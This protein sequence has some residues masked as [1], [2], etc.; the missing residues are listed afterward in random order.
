MIN[1]ALWNNSSRK[2][3]NKLRKEIGN[4]REPRHETEEPVVPQNTEE[5]REPYHVIGVPRYYTEEPYHVIE[6][7]RV[8]RYYTEEP[9]EPYHVIGVPRYYTEEPYHVIEEPRVPR[10]QYV[11]E[12]SYNYLIPPMRQPP[13]IQQPLPMRQQAQ[14]SQEQMQPP[15][16]T[17]TVQEQMQPSQAQISQEQMQPPPQTKDQTQ[18]QIQKANEK[19]QKENKPKKFLDL[20][21]S[22]MNEEEEE[23]ETISEDDRKTIARFIGRQF[24]KEIVK[25]SASY[26]DKIK[27][28]QEKI[29]E[30]TLKLAAKEASK[31]R[32]I[33]DSLWSC[34]SFN[35]KIEEKVTEKVHEKYKK[36]EQSMIVLDQKTIELERSLFEVRKYSCSRDAQKLLDMMNHFVNNYNEYHPTPELNNEY[37]TIIYRLPLI[38]GSKAFDTKY[39][40]VSQKQKISIVS[41][42]KPDVK[43]LIF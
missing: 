25:Q 10:Y 35:H 24:K 14:I 37:Q 30:L 26:D 19:I 36:I 5:P 2:E 28:M 29:Q 39:A 20:M 16:Q 18:I 11:L 40:T 38:I 42:F 23:N 41:A 17:Q 31:P 22:L 6:E 1:K 15:P 33:S 13:P 34:E 12:E 8:P 9:R 4:H 3:K 43:D 7:P 27:E 21:L 32:E